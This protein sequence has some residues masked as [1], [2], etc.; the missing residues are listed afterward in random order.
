MTG[1]DLQSRHEA[2]YANPSANCISTDRLQVKRS[3]LA[4]RANRNSGEIASIDRVLTRRAAQTT[5]EKFRG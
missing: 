2:F 5:R 1:P 4:K 3:E